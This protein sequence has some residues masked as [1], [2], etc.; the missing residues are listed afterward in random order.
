VIHI[1]FAQVPVRV[2]ILRKFTAVDPWHGGSSAE[3]TLNLYRMVM[4]DRARAGQPAFV[5]ELADS[6]KISGDPRQAL[7]RG[8][9]AIGIESGGWYRLMP[10]VLARLGRAAR[11][12]TTCWRA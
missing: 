6:E 11:L 10:R 12:R 1:D 2:Q 8:D 4:E 9:E 5:P 7:L 3:W